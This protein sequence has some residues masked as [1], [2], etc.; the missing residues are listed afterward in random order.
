MNS[1]C[2][3]TFRCVRHAFIQ[4]KKNVI[5]T[6][7]VISP[8]SCFFVVKYWE[9]CYQWWTSMHMNMFNECK[10]FNWFIVFTIHDRLSLCNDQNVTHSIE[11]DYMLYATIPSMSILSIKKKA[12]PIYV[13]SRLPNKSIENVVLTNTI[14]SHGKNRE[15]QTK[16]VFI[17]HQ[18]Q[19]L[20]AFWDSSIIFSLHLTKLLK[21]PYF[22][23]RTAYKHKKSRA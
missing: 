13:G 5:E 7:A 23:M 16:Q 10:G 6:N 18:H 2:I 8:F 14:K 22:G 15:F 17:R 3:W 11:S 4:S 9:K 1:N 19:H 12:F 20:Q 21:Y